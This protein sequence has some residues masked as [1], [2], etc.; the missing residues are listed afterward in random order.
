MIPI[1]VI[2]TT[3]VHQT[4]GDTA[5]SDVESLIRHSLSLSLTHTH[6]LTHSHTHTLTSSP[7]SSHRPQQFCLGFRDRPAACRVR[8][9]LSLSLAEETLLD[10]TL[11]GTST[12]TNPPPGARSAGPSSSLV[13]SG[14]P[15]RDD[16]VDVRPSEEAKWSLGRDAACQLHPRGARPLR[17]DHWPAKHTGRV[18]QE[19]RGSTR[20][21]LSLPRS[22]SGS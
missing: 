11:Y 8:H 2:V 14:E 15:D 6:S 22:M 10:R 7:P 17:P 21:R 4:L 12:V 20:R 5:K 3:T 19:D 9:R 18:S 13:A 1:V 16:E